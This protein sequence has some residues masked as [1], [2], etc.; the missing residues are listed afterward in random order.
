MLTIAPLPAAS[1]AGSAA[2]VVRTA[3]M[4]LMVMV[5]SQSSSVMLRKPPVRAGALPTLFTRMSIRSPASAIR[6]AGPL[7]LGQVD[8]DSA[9]VAG[10]L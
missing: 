2:R 3:A 1:M 8:L 9:D 5:D 10:L 6:L 7:V 4:K